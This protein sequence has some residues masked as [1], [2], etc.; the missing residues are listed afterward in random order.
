MDSLKSLPLKVRAGLLDKADDLKKSGDPRECRKPLTG[1]LQGY[2]RIVYS[3]YRAIF[4][5]EEEPLA[6]GDVLLHLKVVFIV[7][8]TR[9]EFD[10]NDVYR[11]ARKLVEHVLPELPG[12]LDE[13][14]PREKEPE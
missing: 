11:V 7:A 1:P 12:E 14:E 2:Y 13:F 8:G 9:K 5:V 10:R 4:T 6:G 3:R